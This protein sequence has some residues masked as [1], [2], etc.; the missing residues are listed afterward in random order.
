MSVCPWPHE[1]FI[2]PLTFFT[3]RF[4]HATLHAFSALFF[5]YFIYSTHGLDGGSRRLG[6]T[7]GGCHYL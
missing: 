7:K 1:N 2:P 6:T 5:L 4:I 3:S